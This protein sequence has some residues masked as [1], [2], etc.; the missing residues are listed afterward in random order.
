MTFTLPV[1]HRACRSE[2]LIYLVMLRPRTRRPDGRLSRALTLRTI[3]RSLTTTVNNDLISRLVAGAQFDIPDFGAVTA[4]ATGSGTAPS[5]RLL[6]H[7]SVVERTDFGTATVLTSRWRLPMRVKGTGRTVTLTAICA[8][9]AGT[10]CRGAFRRSRGRWVYAH[11][12]SVEHLRSA[13]SGGLK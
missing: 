8:A 1:G 13:D 5:R 2:V 6:R 12:S 10:S 7:W 9:A 4:P 3:R 11:G